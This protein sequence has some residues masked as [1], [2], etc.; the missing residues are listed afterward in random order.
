[1]AP[2]FELICTTS[3]LS[4][5]YN[6]ESDMP[7]TRQLLAL[8]TLG[9][10]TVVSGHLQAAELVPLFNN[11]HLSEPGG[12]MLSK[13]ATAAPA[14]RLKTLLGV[15]DEVSIERSASVVSGHYTSERFVVSYQ[16]IQLLDLSAVLVTDSNGDIVK[17][18]GAIPSN[19]H[20]DLGDL[21]PLTKEA[22]QNALLK[23]VGEYQSKAPEQR[24]IINSK[25]TQ[26]IYIGADN[27]AHHVIVMRVFSDSDGQDPQSLRWLVDAATG[28]LLEELNLLQ[29]ERVGGAGPSGNG[30]V[31]APEYRAEDGTLT[32]PETFMVERQQEGIH[33]LCYFKADNVETR[34]AEHESDTGGLSDEPYKY[35]CAQSTRN[36]YK[37]INTA[38]SPLN[39]AHYRGQVTSR[40][41]EDY[42]GHKPYFDQNIVQYV[43]YGKSYDNAF[44]EDGA[45]YFGD[46]GYLYYP[47]VSLNTVA[48]EIAHGYTAG[49]GS[50]GAEK[51][52]R[53]GQAQSINEAF[54][55]IAGEAAE[56]YLTGANDWLVGE[57]TWPQE[58][59]VR[60]MN[61]PTL[62]DKSVDHID[63]YT[64]G[65]DGHFG[66]GIFNKAFFALATNARDPKGPWDTELAFYAF[67]L[68]NKSCW[69]ADSEFIDAADCVMRQASAVAQALQKKNVTAAD[70]SA[71]TEQTLANQIRKAFTTVGIELQTSSG[72]AANFN[73]HSA[74]LQLSTL[75]T[76]QYDG[77]PLSEAQSQNGWQYH[78]DFGDGTPLVSGFN[79]SHTYNA[80]NTYT[81][82]L[83][84][85]SPSG[86]EDEITRVVTIEEDY[87]QPTEPAT[88]DYWIRQVAIA[89]EVRNLPL[90]GYTDATATPLSLAAGKP[91]R[92]SVQL[93]A[94]FQSEEQSRILGVWLDKNNDG[95]FA[96]SE[97]LSIDSVDWSISKVS[98][99]VGETGK[100][101]RVRLTASDDA[102]K[103]PS[104]GASQ[105]GAT[106]DLAV[107]WA[108]APPKSLVWLDQTT[109][110][111]TRFTVS[112]NDERVTSYLWNF[113]DGTTSTE[114][115]PTHAFAQTGSYS[116]ELMA[117]NGQGNALYHQQREV[118]FRTV[119]TP[120]FFYQ[121]LEGLTVRFSNHSSFPA[122][123]TFLWDFGDGSTSSEES[124][125]HT[126]AAAG[127]Y[128]IKL[129]ITNTDVPQGI[130]DTGSVVVGSD[131]PGNTS[132]TAT[133]MRIYDGMHA[134]KFQF[135]LNHT[136][137][138]KHSEDWE[139]VW[140]FG[141]GSEG[142]NSS[143]YTSTS[144]IHN[145]TQAGTFT[146]KLT[147]RYKQR[148]GSGE[149]DWQWYEKDFELPVSLLENQPNAYCNATGDVTFEHIEN[150]SINGVD[151]ATN[152]RGGLI[153][154]DEPIL[155]HP[156]NNTYYIQAGYEGEISPARYHM[157]LDI[158]QDFWFGGESQDT[159]SNEYVLNRLDYLD[160]STG[161]GFISGFFDLPE[162]AT[163]AGTYFSQLRILQQYESFYSSS[164]SPCA[165]YPEDGYNTGEIEDY[166]VKWVV[167]ATPVVT[168][169]V[170]KKRV[171]FT[172]T[173]TARNDVLW[174]WDFGDGETSAL[175][176]PTHNYS[177]DGTY[178]VNLKIQGSDTTPLGEWQT[179]LTISSEPEPVPTELVLN[180]AMQDNLMTY[181]ITGSRYPAGSTVEIDFG[182]NK[183]SAN[184]T[185]THEYRTAGTYTVTLTVTNADYPEGKQTSRSVVVPLPPQPPKSKSGGG[186]LGGGL[187]FLLAITMLSRTRK[188]KRRY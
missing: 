85:T 113:G 52:M 111:E 180:V 32:P 168:H 30:K 54:S 86:A 9:A 73:S 39:D 174:L 173:T 166:R 119:T 95:Q 20:A 75:N 2:L 43:H 156:E 33:T 59:P 34:S 160:R 74:F 47:L 181:N 37:N 188:D 16:G 110:N 60:Y 17:G 99:F 46:G 29:H 81:V 133:T 129:T 157:W 150:V 154:P 42:L 151:Y 179:S 69:V 149:N 7:F 44:Y 142:N 26:A 19:L 10:A 164:V 172:N 137:Q 123:S 117:K 101:Y 132:F 186:S 177:A 45:V 143:S 118:E 8:V 3:Q 50:D 187:L 183:K 138:D 114:K 105:G 27:T 175:R 120:Y 116:V 71:W 182:D 135:K 140:Q 49:Y 21:T 84:I 56:F 122:G 165:N 126:Y 159:E 158:N 155:L 65:M 104:C 184:P 23:Q 58:H 141:D 98:D 124:P 13:P 112:T 76:S 63:Q 139:Y 28:Q 96:L 61:N 162:L 87:C 15:D 51:L 64:N 136:P 146:A 93:G 94:E 6:S 25:V 91:L 176:N 178:L 147:F 144:I 171:V 128:A 125:E 163:A 121:M 108:E 48:H 102:R 68:A 77:Q 70:G 134:V 22:L 131:Q 100:T 55:D 62:D 167:P 89:G 1:M 36:A 41:F 57:D 148:T 92:Y 130:T 67:A 35:D 90:A 161:R 78:W 5:N 31:S 109:L 18:Y 14:A 145:Y 152:P 185:G 88:E 82:S 83:L 153:N 72:I 107:T 24:R 79:A 66:S 115:N 12:V 4:S 169:T 80:A 170:N 40:M 38:L 106:V 103:T 127:N 97:R 11:S 53:R